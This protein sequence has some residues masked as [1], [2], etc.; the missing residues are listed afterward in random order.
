MMKK[1]ISGF[2]LVEIILVVA[3]IS[4]L[5]FSVYSTSSK[6]LI[7]N[8]LE[9][10]LN[11]LVSSLRTAQINSIN[12]KGTA[13]WGVNILS[14][15]I[16]LFYGDSYA[17]RDDSYDQIYHIS[18]SVTVTPKEI[19]FNRVEGN[20][21]SGLVISVTNNVGESAQ[22]SINQQGIIDVN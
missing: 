7:K 10:S 3:I 13:K 15:Q 19:I 12:S 16:I 20:V 5:S 11:N 2:T 21:A 22:V 18:K 1:H 6:F 8:N 17:G 14:D 4:L 9:D